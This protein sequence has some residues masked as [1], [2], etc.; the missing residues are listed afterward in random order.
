MSALPTQIPAP[1]NNL[2]TPQKTEL[3]KLLF[4]DPILS[5][6]QD[7][8]CATCYRPDFAEGLEFSIGVNG[9]G[10]GS[11]RVFWSPNDIPFVKRNSQSVVNTVF[12]GLTHKTAANADAAPMFWDFWAKSLEKQSLE[13]IKIPEEMRGHNFAEGKIMGEVLRRLVNNPTYVKLFHAAFDSENAVTAE[14]M[15]K[16]I[17]TYERSMPKRVPS[18]LKVEGDI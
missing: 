17:A 6:N 10:L 13:P 14:N 15:A 16:A 5:G 3:G 2:I 18:G 11:R 1:F 4:S 12:N 9:S 8:A 7:V